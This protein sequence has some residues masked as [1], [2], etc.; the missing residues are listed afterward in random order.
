MKYPDNLWPTLLY[1]ATG[2]SHFPT[3]TGAFEKELLELDGDYNCR[4]DSIFLGYQQDEMKSLD[5]YMPIVGSD[6]LPFEFESG[7]P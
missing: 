4:M 3:E 2:P 6:L 5:G 1:I 7:V